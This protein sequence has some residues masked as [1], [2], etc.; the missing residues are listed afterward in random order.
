MPTRDGEGFACL[1]AFAAAHSGD[2]IGRARSI[3]LRSQDEFLYRVLYMAGYRQRAVLCGF[4]LPFDLSRLARHAGAARSSR[5]RGD[6][7]DAPSATYRGG[8]SFA[9]WGRER[10]GKW[11]DR[12]SMPRIAINSLDSKRALIGFVPPKGGRWFPGEFLDLRTLS[13]ALTDE[14]HSLAS[15]CTAFGV[16]HGKLRTEHHG[17]IDRAYLTYARRDVLATSELFV[18]VITE[19]LRHPIDLPPSKAFSPAAIGKAY[20]AAMGVA[21]ILERQPDFPKD[22]LGIAMQAYVGGRAETRIRKEPVPVRYCDFRSMYPTVCALMGAWP[23]LTAERIEVRDAIAKVRR[24]LSGVNPSTVFEPSIWMSLMGF[25][26]IETNDDIIP[27]RGQY[28]LRS[29]W[30]IGVNPVRPGH[31]Q[32]ISIPDAVASTLLTG[33]PP[34]V[35]RAIVLAPRGRLPGLRSVALGGTIPIDPRTMDFFE[36]VIERRADVLRSA[37][38]DGAERARLGQFLK[39]LAN[40]T[41]YGIF[42]EQNRRQLPERETEKVTVHL[43]DRTFETTTSAPEDLGRYFFPPIAAVITGAARLML[44][45]LERSVLDAGGTYAM[46][47]TDSMAIVA[48]ARGDK[49]AAIPRLSWAEV[50][51]IRARFRRLSPYDPSSVPDLLKLEEENLDEH[52]RPRE[53]ECF[54]ISAKRYALFV[55][56]TRGDPVIVKA[57]EHGLGHLLDPTGDVGDPKAW[58]RTTWLWIIRRELG[59]VA[60]VPKWFASPAIGAVPVSSPTMRRPFAELNRG[61]T[62]DETV[63]PFN[64]V[65]A[66]HVGPFGHPTGVEPERFQLVAPFEKDPAKWLGLEWIDRYSGRQYQVTTSGPVGAIGVARVKSYGDVVTEYRAHKEDKGLG[67]NGSPCG[68]EARGLLLRRSVGVRDVKY[69]GKEANELDERDAGVHHRLDE[70]LSTYDDPKSDHW[71]ELVR[72]IPTATLTR[73]SGRDRSTIKRWKAGQTRPH[74]RDQR[75]LGSY[76]V[77]RWTP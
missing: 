65:L 28:S 41:S 31:R 40:A 6:G 54:A 62:Y 32:W 64:F 39:T 61:R 15:A 51:E 57:S 10:D 30:S 20:L 29:G 74:A 5:K 7:D 4:N 69:I 44:A 26:E 19:Y 27:V 67:P 43:P 33:S 76:L 42:A 25:A 18:A 21:P 50:D 46:V 71:Q 23:L 56:D 1:Q 11:H 68:P 48:S 70:I 47:D 73:A 66:A 75:S 8:F 49:G 72:S 24:L 9:Y 34:K 35:L 13:F 55:R 36:A 53:L 58:M 59:L 52:G 22:V 60:T 45:L 16:E 37:E 2:T 38:K 63:K 12:P 77:N 17:S 3:R 14:S